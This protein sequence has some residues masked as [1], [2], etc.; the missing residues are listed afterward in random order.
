MEFKNLHN[1]G[2][3]EKKPCVYGEAKIVVSPV[4]YE[5]AP[6]YGKGVKGGPRAIIEASNN[7]ESFDDELFQDTYDI[8]GIHTLKALKVGKAKPEVVINRVEGTVKSI[9]N[10]GKFPVTLGGGHSVSIG[11]AMAF[12][13]RFKNFSVL[14][15][16][17]H[18]DMRDSYMGSKYNH[19]CVAR[20]IC[21]YFPLVQVGARSLSKDEYDFLKKSKN[22]HAVGFCDMLKN[23]GWVEGCLDRLSENVYVTIDLDVFDPAIMPSTGTPEPGGM[24]WIEVLGVLR[25]ISQQKNV[26]GFDVV[27]LS[28]VRG[29]A[30]PDFLTAKLI[31]RFLGYIALKSKKGG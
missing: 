8:L 3:S 21:E 6:T 14:Q 26:V 1:F 7:M 17:A 24:N 29:M 31:Y 4:P 18:C 9:L 13:N 16:D 15:L 10:D 12:R 2:D 20:R 27:E 22:V 11:C 25:K 30:A 5:F 23:P 19:A 28:P